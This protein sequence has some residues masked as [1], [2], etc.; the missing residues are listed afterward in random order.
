MNH[1]IKS[2]TVVEHHTRRPSCRHSKVVTATIDEAIDIN[3]AWFYRM[4]NGK[5]YPEQ[6]I[7]RIIKNDQNE[8]C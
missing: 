3:W 8:T 6:F 2:G 4:T 5:T 1:P 7:R